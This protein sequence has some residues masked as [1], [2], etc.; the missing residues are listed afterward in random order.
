[1]FIYE[2]LTKI[3]SEFTEFRQDMNAFRYETKEN[4]RS[5]KNDVL[6][7]E[8]GHGSKLGA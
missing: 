5:L 4:I 6:W 8:Q 3:Y 7:V 2:L 1:M